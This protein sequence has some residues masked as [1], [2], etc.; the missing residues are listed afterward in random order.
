MMSFACEILKNLICWSMKIFIWKVIID[1]T[2]SA[3]SLIKIDFQKW[4][5]HLPPE[6]AKLPTATK[7]LLSSLQAS[8]TKNLSIKENM[9]QLLK[10]LLKSYMKDCHWNTILFDLCLVLFQRIWLKVNI[11]Q[12]SLRKLCTSFAQ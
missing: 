2:D 12:V 8:M 4:E 10:V 6:S 3:Y 1:V 7:T 5:N 11:V 9:L